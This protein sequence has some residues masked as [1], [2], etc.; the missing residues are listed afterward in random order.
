MTQSFAPLTWN[1][2]GRNGIKLYGRISNYPPYGTSYLSIKLNLSSLS[3]LCLYSANY[4][5]EKQI[6]LKPPPAFVLTEVKATV[7]LFL[8]AWE[9]QMLSLVGE[10]QL[11]IQQQNNPYYC[12]YMVHTWLV[13]V[14]CTSSWSADPWPVQV[15]E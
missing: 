6:S 13:Q 14:S 2:I 10:S 12:L 9:T 11:Y 5:K 8:K 1:F 15:M 4:G 3:P 7:N